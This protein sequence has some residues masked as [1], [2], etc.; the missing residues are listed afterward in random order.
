MKAIGNLFMVIVVLGVGVCG[1]LYVAGYSPG[2][3]G[4]LI[5][6]RF[7]ERGVPTPPP[8]PPKTGQP[9]LEPKR[10]P[11]L[12][13]ARDLT[14]TW[15]SASL[16]YGG[17][18]YQLGD[19]NPDCRF[20]YDVE[21]KLTQKGNTLT[22]TMRVYNGEAIALIDRP[23][24]KPGPLPDE[25]ISITGT[26]AGLDLQFKAKNLVFKATKLTS[27]FMQGTIS[28]PPSSG[29]P[30]GYKGEFHLERR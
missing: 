7:M 23:V 2:D 30:H 13:P 26:I 11:M 25:M 5:Q 29:A 1:G 18:Y 22:G 15:R 21:L 12:S 20:E 4:D 8:T 19:V 9:K 10:D 27:D 17:L 6:Q 16:K 3:L 24:C 14:G 28:S